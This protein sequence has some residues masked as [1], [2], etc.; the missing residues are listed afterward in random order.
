LSKYVEVFE[1]MWKYEKVGCYKKIKSYL[2]FTM[3]NSD[4]ESKS[5]R[6]R[7]CPAGRQGVLGHDHRVTI[8][9]NLRKIKLSWNNFDS[10]A[11]VNFTNIFRQLC[12]IQELHTKKLFAVIVCAFLMQGN[13][14]KGSSLDV[15]ETGNMQALWNGEFVSSKTHH[16][17]PTL[18]DK[19]TVTELFAES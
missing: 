8:I 7:S 5:F 1:S 15:S 16:N 6:V 14:R 2:C 13:C 3:D 11:G 4:A 12:Y 17:E 18:K 19:L 10:T 9:G